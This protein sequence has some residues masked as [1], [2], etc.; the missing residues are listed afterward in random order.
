MKRHPHLSPEGTVMRGKL[1]ASADLLVNG[2]RGDLDTISETLSGVTLLLIEMLAN[3][4]PT[5]EECRARIQTALAAHKPAKRGMTFRNGERSIEGVP[6]HYFPL[7][8]A[9][10]VL[11]VA[12]WR[13]TIPAAV[14]S[15]AR[16]VAER[17]NS[18][19]IVA[20][21]DRLERF[22]RAAGLLPKGGADGQ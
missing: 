19:E 13:G 2:K 5:A 4:P 8:L 11:I 22:V 1:R 20:K 14:E 3:Q 15:Y 9:A 7:I 17:T 16:T 10:V 6:R 18:T 21:L 12:L